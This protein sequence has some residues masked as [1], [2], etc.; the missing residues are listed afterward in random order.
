MGRNSKSFLDCEGNRPLGRGQ[1]ALRAEMKQVVS[2]S[3]KQK[4]PQFVPVRYPFSHPAERNL[5]G[6]QGEQ[7]LRVHRKPVGET[8]DQGRLGPD[9]VEPELPI[10]GHQRFAKGDFDHFSI[11]RFKKITMKPDLAGSLGGD[12]ILVSSRVKK[13]G[14]REASLGGGFGKILGCPQECPPIH[15]REEEFGNYCVVAVRPEFFKGY[16]SILRPFDLIIQGMEDPHQV[17]P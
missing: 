15:D 1:G 5:L 3:L 6:Q 14:K 17:L 16:F 4:V 9:E 12:R 13:D 11:E 8:C 10:A 7:V 2:K